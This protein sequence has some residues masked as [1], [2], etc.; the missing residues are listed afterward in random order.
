MAVFGA[1]GIRDAM[2]KSY[3]KHV[4]LA[5]QHGTPPETSVHAC[6][7][8]GALSSRYL[9]GFEQVAE[10][11]VWAELAPFVHLQPSLGSEA[12]AEY[13]VYK[14]MPSEARTGWLQQTVRDGLAL[15]DVESGEAFVAMAKAVGLAWSVFVE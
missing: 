10:P 13:V 8:Y 6:G 5:R 9:A 11:E 7:L 15:W 12:L 3:H 4:E 2:M 1:Q 14:E